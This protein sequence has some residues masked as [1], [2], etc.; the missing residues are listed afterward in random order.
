MC[1]ILLY[2]Y[3]DSNVIF[4]NDNYIKLHVEH[5]QGFVLSFFEFTLYSEQ[6]TMTLKHFLMSAANHCSSL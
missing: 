1:R 4:V 6:L 5:V 3:K 2:I